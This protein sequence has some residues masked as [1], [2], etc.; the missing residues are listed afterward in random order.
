[1]LEW[2][3]TRKRRQAVRQLRENLAYFGYSLSGYSDA[4]LLARVDKTPQIVRASCT[5]DAEAAYVYQQLRVEDESKNV[6][7]LNA[8]SD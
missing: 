6:N 5:T 8:A 7:G 3:R 2:L 4:Q 1:M